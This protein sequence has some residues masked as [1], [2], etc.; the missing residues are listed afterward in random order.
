MVDT[1]FDH[2]PAPNA[3]DSHV[4]AYFK[5][6]AWTD[7]THKAFVSRLKAIL[8]TAGLQPNKYAAQSLRRGGATYAFQCGC[9]TEY[10]KALG[11]WKSG[12]YL[13]YLEIDTSLRIQAA[14]IISQ[15]GTT[16]PAITALHFAHY[17]FSQFVG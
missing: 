9:T 4:F 11:D 1:T 6:G 17:C 5:N 15:H 13:L 3:S 2:Q 14:R 16:Y 8:T 10:I 12:A 7:L